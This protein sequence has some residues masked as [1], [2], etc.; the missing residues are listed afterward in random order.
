MA[1][2][3]S[4]FWNPAYGE[5]PLSRAAADE[6]DSTMT[7]PRASSSM[8]MPSDEVVGRERAVKQPEAAGHPALDPGQPGCRQRPASGVA[9]P[10]GVTVLTTALPAA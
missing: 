6:V 4:C 9:L 2:P 1:T 5:P 8:V 7:R 10:A 3:R